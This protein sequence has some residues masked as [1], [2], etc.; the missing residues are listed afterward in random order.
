M[1]QVLSVLTALAQH[2]ALERGAGR[3]TA[4]QRQGGD[5]ACQ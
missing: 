1:S 5:P 2:G 4:D 3:V